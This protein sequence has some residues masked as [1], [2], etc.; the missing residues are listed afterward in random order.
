MLRKGVDFTEITSNRSMSAYGCFSRLYDEDEGAAEVDVIECTR[1]PTAYDHP[2]NTNIKFWDLPGIGT[3][4][5]PDLETY[6]EKVQLE[7]YHTYLIFTATRFTKHDLEL[8]KKVRSIDKKFFFIRTQID[9]CVR[10]ERRKR[11][12]DEE[13]MLTKIRRDS[14]ERLGDLL[15]NEKDIFLISSHEPENWEFARLT[16]AILVAVK[17]YQ[18]EA[19]TRNQRECII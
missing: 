4:S 19:L 9:E 7:T 3:P 13:T 11:S 5:Y 8:A 12:F 1:E 16:E 17:R 15:S 10:A 14:L 2:I 6:C 18:R